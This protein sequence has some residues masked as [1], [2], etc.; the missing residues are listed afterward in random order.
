M[1]YQM[2]S[3]IKK[4]AKTETGQWVDMIE[5]ALSVLKCLLLGIKGSK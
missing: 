4:L 5:G 2:I 3:K 1:F